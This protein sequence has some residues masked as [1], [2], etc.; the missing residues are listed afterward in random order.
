MTEVK[1]F[2]LAVD[3]PVVSLVSLEFHDSE[4][5][6]TATLVFMEVEFIGVGRTAAVLLLEYSSS[7][8]LSITQKNAYYTET[9]DM[10]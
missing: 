2:M 6:A 1:I 7:S 5:A 9:I 3:S 4:P 10:D 8:M